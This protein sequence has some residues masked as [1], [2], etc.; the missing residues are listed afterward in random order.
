ML[1]PA[2]I[3]GIANGASPGTALF[4][5]WC[6][7]NAD[8]FGYESAR[9]QNLTI[10]EAFPAVG[11]STCGPTASLVA[12]DV[13][14]ELPGR[15]ATQY[16]RAL[17]YTFPPVPFTVEGFLWMDPLTGTTSRFFWSFNTQGARPHDHIVQ[18]A[19]ATVNIAFCCA[20][21]SYCANVTR[22]ASKSE[23]CFV[24]SCTSHSTSVLACTR[25]LHA[26]FVFANARAPS[27]QAT[28]IACL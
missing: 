8:D 15:T 24:L 17:T 5:N 18:T 12:R 25:C 28:I 21:S 11:L 4:A 16:A 3:A 14:Y 13:A 9:G 1:A 2:R 20:C 23:T 6:F 27:A 22:A 26:T 10:H 7:S 19:N